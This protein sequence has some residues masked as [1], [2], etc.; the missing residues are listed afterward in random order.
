MLGDGAVQQLS[1]LGAT[2]WLGQSQA[3]E[4]SHPHGMT[5]GTEPAKM[6]SGSP[7]GEGPDWT[8]GRNDLDRT[9]CVDL[10]TWTGLTVCVY[11]LTRTALVKKIC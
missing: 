2:W 6:R 10:L 9:D 1:E 8:R 5:G 3:T 4:F 7:D 11:L